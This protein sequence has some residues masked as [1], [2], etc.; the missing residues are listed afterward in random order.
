[1]L[2]KKSIGRIM[3]SCCG[4]Q[5][6]DII[7]E[8]Y[9]SKHTSIFYYEHKQNR[10]FMI[11]KQTLLIID[12]TNYI[13][14]CPHC[15]KHLG[16]YI[17]GDWPDV[18]ASF[19]GRTDL[20]ICATVNWINSFYIY[21]KVE[22]EPS[23]GKFIYIEHDWCILYYPTGNVEHSEFKGYQ[24]IS[25]DGNPTVC[26]WKN[27]SP[28]LINSNGEIL[29]TII[30]RSINDNAGISIFEVGS[31]ILQYSCRNRNWQYTSNPAL[32][33]KPAVRE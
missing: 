19:D 15:K 9:F 17:Y 23:F 11:V 10:I 25:V 31:G 24:H 12:S 30:V 3:T 4:Q 7:S 8:R 22:N 14:S 26:C 6:E 1:M 21:L 16:I 33:T 13:K 18:R 5:H 28:I 20:P 2:T 29:E 27:W 32:K